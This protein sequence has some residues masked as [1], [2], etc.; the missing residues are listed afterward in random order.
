M[1]IEVFKKSWDKTKERQLYGIVFFVTF[2][3]V[4]LFICFVFSALHM[5]TSNS[6]NKANKIAMINEISQKK[7]LIYNFR[8]IK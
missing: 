1:L 7:Y 5:K 3:C 6:I 2:A 4:W 8:N